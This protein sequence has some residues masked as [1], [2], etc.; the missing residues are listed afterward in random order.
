MPWDIAARVISAFIILEPLVSISLY[1]WLFE[2]Y[3]CIASHQVVN[4][5]FTIWTSGVDVSLAGCGQRAKL[6]SDQGGV[7]FVTFKCKDWVVGYVLG[8][9][10]CIAVSLAVAIV[11]VWIL[12]RQGHS[13]KSVKWDHFPNIPDFQ[14]LVFA[15]TGYLDAITFTADIRDTFSMTNE[16]SSRPIRVQRSSIPNLDQRVIRP[17]KNHVTVLSVDETNTI[18]VISVGGFQPWDHLVARQVV[19]QKLGGLCGADNLIAVTGKL[20]RHDASAPS[21][22]TIS[23][24]AGTKVEDFLPSFQ[25]L[26]VYESNPV[27]HTAVNEELLVRIH[28]HVWHRPANSLGLYFSL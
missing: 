10:I 17:C 26:Q 3:R 18:D 2:D 9:P 14:K 1:F 8:L 28:I 6:A 23:V 27:V 4:E 11:E 13:F 16:N 7:Y 21:H 22:H 24:L 15:I 19:A 5:N 20:C 25:C 12:H